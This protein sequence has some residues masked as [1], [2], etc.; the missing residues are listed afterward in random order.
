MLL[1]RVERAT[2]AGESDR[3]IGLIQDRLGVTPEHSPYPQ[4]VLGT[5]EAEQEGRARFRA[6][7]LAGTRANVPGRIDPYRLARSAVQVSDGMRWWRRRVDGAMR[8]EDD[9]RRWVNERRYANS[10]Q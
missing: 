3:S 2:E 8:L 1:D 7:A 6:A 4:A 9:L 10:T 5:V